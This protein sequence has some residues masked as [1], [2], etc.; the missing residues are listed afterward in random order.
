MTKYPD[1]WVD[2]V[3]IFNKYQDPQTSVIRWYRTVVDGCFWKN[4]FQR[5]KVGQIEVSTDSIICRI[6]EKDNYLDKHVW[7][8]IPND[9]KSNYFT[10]SEGDIVVRGNIQEGIN[11]YNSG[12][13]SSDFITKYKSLGCM[14]L[15]RISI[16]TGTGKGIPH[17]HVEGV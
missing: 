5:L 12:E 14:I 13:R 16:N 8:T 11:E 6:P 17:Y 7:L 15:D 3:T 10:L 4:D 1:W 2:T 9:M